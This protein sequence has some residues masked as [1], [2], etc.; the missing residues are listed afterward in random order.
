[1]YIFWKGVSQ[2]NI[3]LQENYSVNMFIVLFTLLSIFVS[4]SRDVTSGTQ[5]NVT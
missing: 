4:A 3:I 2:C 1:M 5:R